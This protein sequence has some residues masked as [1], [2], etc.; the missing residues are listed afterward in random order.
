MFILYFFNAKDGEIMKRK[1]KIQVASEKTFKEG[2]E[3]FIHNCNAR[4]LIPAT[5]THYHPFGIIFS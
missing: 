4:N 1:L 2:F 5:I 3:E